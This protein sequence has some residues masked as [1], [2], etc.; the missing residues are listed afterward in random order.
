MR[1]DSP[2]RQ[3]SPHRGDKTSN[4]PAWPRQ[5]ARSASYPARTE[6]R[7]TPGAH[8]DSKQATNDTQTVRECS[9]LKRRTKDY[10]QTNPAWRPSWTSVKHAAARRLRLT[11]G[12]RAG[13]E[14]HGERRGE[15]GT[16]ADRP[17]SLTPEK[18]ENVFIQRTNTVKHLIHPQNNA[19]TC[20]GS[21]HDIWLQLCF[22]FH[23]C[24]DRL[25]PK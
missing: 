17:A 12:E 9:V 10:E 16:C 3:L 24:Y 5:A 25:M 13:V 23:S 15:R 18:N 2:Q 4:R 6:R 11:T 22:S 14:R 19:D 7:H 21:P 8:A 1:T 20:A